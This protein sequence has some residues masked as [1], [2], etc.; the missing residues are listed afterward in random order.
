M[1]ARMVS[2]HLKPGIFA[3]ATQTLESDVIPL[4]RKQQGFR[5]EVSIFDESKEEAISITFWDNKKDAEK[6]ARETYPRVLTTMESLL[7]GAP[8]VRSFEVS[9]STWYKIHAS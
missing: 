6:Y 4:L 9:N 5:D 8:Q 2:T 7:E 1:F 3:E